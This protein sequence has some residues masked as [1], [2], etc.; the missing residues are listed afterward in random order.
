MAD[1]LALFAALERPDLKIIAL[2]RPFLKSLPHV[3]KRP[4]FVTDDLAARMALVRQVSGHLRSGGAALTFPAGRIEPDP[5]VS[6]DTVR[7]LDNWTDSV[8]VFVR[9]AP[10]TVILPMLVR[11]VI[12]ERTARHVLTHFKQTREEREKLAAALQ[13]LAQVFLRLKPVSV[14]V[15]VGRP[16]TIASL[17]SKEMR[18]IHQAVLAEMRDLIANPPRGE[19]RPVL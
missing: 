9:M 2:D 12:W 15:Q 7:S 19:G 16:I 14:D 1:T 13:L 18:V 17:G 11:G 4:Y 5:A 10:E 3:S 8:G 6:P